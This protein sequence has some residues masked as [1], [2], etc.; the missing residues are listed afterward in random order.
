MAHDEPPELV[1]CH[2][3][4]E[5]GLASIGKRKGLTGRWCLDGFLEQR[6]Q[7]GRMTD[8][9]APLDGSKAGEAYDE[10]EQPG[11]PV[12]GTTRAPLLRGVPGFCPARW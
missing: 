11:Q 12:L 2:R 7:D 6:W 1:L 10:E 9:G 4:H 5:I 3:L 8:E